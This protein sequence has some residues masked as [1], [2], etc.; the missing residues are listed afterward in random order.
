MATKRKRS[1]QGSNKKEQQA[2]SQTAQEHIPQQQQVQKQKGRP[3]TAF[4]QRLFKVGFL[5]CQL[6]GDVH[7][8]TRI[9]TGQ[10]N[11][12]STWLG[13]VYCM[14]T[15]TLT[16]Q[17]YHHAVVQADP[18]GQGVYVWCNGQ[19][20]RQQRKGSGTGEAARP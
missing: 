6:A 14:Y 3:D 15:N 16:M 5:R 17:C 4:E 18:S 1:Q 8:H 11:W 19:G 9:A 12:H 10:G 2:D 20:A 13:G 7:M